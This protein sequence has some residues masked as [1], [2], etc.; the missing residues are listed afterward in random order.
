[1]AVQ[2]PVR[3][4]DSNSPKE[5]NGAGSS[6]PSAADR[7]QNAKGEKAD[8]TDLLLIVFVH[9][10]KGTDETFGAFPKRLQHIL[11]ETITEVSVECIVFPAYEVG[12]IAHKTEARL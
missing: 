6:S 9:G 10:F 2:R 1:M 4:M 7:A 5:S 11:T 3:V 12:P 8:V